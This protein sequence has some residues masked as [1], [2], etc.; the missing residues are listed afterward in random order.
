MDVKLNEFKKT[1][2]TLAFCAV[3]FMDLAQDVVVIDKDEQTTSLF[4]YDDPFSLVSLV[5]FNWIEEIKPMD[6][7]AIQHL[8]ELNWL[9]SVYYFDGKTVTTPLI[10][11]DPDSPNFGEPL[12]FEDPETGMITF[13]YPETPRYY[14]D[15]DDITRI[16]LYKGQVLNPI[17]G[18]KYFGIKEIGFAKKYLNDK[19]YTVT[20]KIPFAYL[21]RMDAFK[22]IVKL[23]EEVKK[24]LSDRTNER[25]LFNQVMEDRLSRREKGLTH[26]RDTAR[27]NVI[28][29]DYFDPSF[30][31][32]SY[33]FSRFRLP[34][35][36]WGEKA[37]GYNTHSIAF[38]HSFETP[39]TSFDEK[40]MDKHFN[41]IDTTIQGLS[42]LIDDDP[43]S[44]NFGEPITEEYEDGTLH[45]VYPEES[46]PFYVDFEPRNTYVLLDF[47][48][49]DTK[50]KRNFG[51][52]PEQILFT[53][54]YE[55][56]EHL[57]FNVYFFEENM[58]PLNNRVELN[59]FNQFCAD[60]PTY[61]KLPWRMQ[62]INSFDNAKDLQEVGS[63]SWNIQFN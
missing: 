29:V 45:Y 18:E 54:A 43:N 1:V 9:D 21:M 48:Y 27:R 59:K 30:K 31:I 4:N 35:N 42:P 47:T 36:E 41:V 20:M 17:T 16:L 44:P 50:H 11:E 39:F 7:N 13:I 3:A 60:L 62:I 12:T 24:E 58:V 61:D 53:G 22:T 14:Y 25:S 52:L 46:F 63:K 28:A 23:P 56:K 6:S 38:K 26:E 19:K 10:D 34:L 2:T 5:K 49:M 8:K 33:G 32:M 40:I 15:V 57:I 37:Q 55:D 51:L